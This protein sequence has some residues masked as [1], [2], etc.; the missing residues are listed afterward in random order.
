MANKQLRLRAL[1]ERAEGDWGRAVSANAVGN[2]IALAIAGAVGA[3]A[4]GA[5]SQVLAVGITALNSASN[6]LLAPIQLPL[7]QC[8]FLAALFTFAGALFRR[9]QH[10]PATSLFA[11]TTTAGMNLPALHAADPMVEDPGDKRYLIGLTIRAKV[12]NV[13]PVHALSPTA[14]VEHPWLKFE[15]APIGDLAPGQQGELF[16]Q[17]REGSIPPAGQTLLGDFRVQIK[18]RDG[19][20]RWRQTITPARLGGWRGGDGLYEDLVAWFDGA[21]ERVEQPYFRHRP[22]DV[23]LP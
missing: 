18:Y 9:G 6:L 23:S 4:L 12:I 13:G 7:W 10:A 22:R 15:A 16:L 8:A 5:A 20:G 1:L 17:A 11:P 19:E 2:L 3:L 14:I 21:N